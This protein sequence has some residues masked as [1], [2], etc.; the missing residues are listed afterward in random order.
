MSELSASQKL[1]AEKAICIMLV[2]G[3]SPDDK[4]IYAYVAVRA[5]KLEAFIKAQ[6]RG[7]FDPE[8]FGVIIEAGEGTPT[9]EIMQK[10]QDEYGFNHEHMVTIPPASEESS[11]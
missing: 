2:R 8:K 3:Y 7:D 5:D 9:Q 4:P 11:S 1:L 10:M 6:R